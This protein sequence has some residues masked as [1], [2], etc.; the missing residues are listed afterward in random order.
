MDPASPSPDEDCVQYEYDGT[1]VLTLKHV[2]AGFNCCPGKITADIDIEN[3]VITI[4]EHESESA[5]R[6]LCL[7]D[8]DYKIEN[9]QPGEYE[10]KFAELYLDSGDDPLEFTCDLSQAP[11]GTYCVKRSHYPWDMRVSSEPSGSLL[12]V[13]GCK[14]QTGIQS[15][16]STKA[17][18]DCIE[19]DYIQ[20][21]IL[22]LKHIN[23][24]FNCCPVLDVDIAIDNGV[25]TIIES[26]TEGLCD[27]YC[28]F[29]LHYMIMN[30]PPGEYNISVDEHYEQAGDEKLEFTINLVESPSGI[31]CV[32]RNHSPW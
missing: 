26:E 29:D 13:I 24:G 9:L 4:V 2:N 8:V 28:L 21:N 7:F 14:D 25:I 1:G 10:I 5:C 20:D 15:D 3:N 18:Q 22:L 6:C 27:C 12:E 19:Y 16:Q 32:E 23:A 31:F 17:V 30:L 11:S